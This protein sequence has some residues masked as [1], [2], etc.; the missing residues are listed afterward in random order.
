MPGFIA[1]YRGVTYHFNRRTDR[2]PTTMQELFN[3]RHSKLRSK[4]ECA[5]A[6][7]K[8]RWCIL[9]E[10]KF[11]DFPTQVDIVLACCL[12]HN[13][14]LTVDPNDTLIVQDGESVNPQVVEEELFDYEQF[15]Q[16]TQQSQRNAK[17]DWEEKRDDIARR[18][19]EDY[20]NG[21][22]TD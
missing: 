4:I 12:L 7:L 20:Q 19:W 21:E 13:Y 2:R 3:Y 5:F 11:H 22:G 1:P 15:T 9:E 6:T 8:N 14:I 16:D 10:K 17:R 18:M